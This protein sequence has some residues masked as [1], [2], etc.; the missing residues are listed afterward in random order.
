M[1]NTETTESL[2]PFLIRVGLL[3]SVALNIFAW[4]YIQH[5]EVADKEEKQV[6]FFYPNMY[7]SFSPNMYESF[8]IVPQAKL[9]GVKQQVIP[10]Y[11]GAVLNMWMRHNPNEKFP[12]NLKY[13][14]ITSFYYKGSDWFDHSVTFIDSNTKVT[15]IKCQKYNEALFE[16]QKLYLL[17]NEKCQ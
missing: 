11:E 3:I 10:S 6:E 16:A 2:T 1:E 15:D 14:L 17:N 13:C 5:L 8:E 12:N 7:E 4:I 9:Y